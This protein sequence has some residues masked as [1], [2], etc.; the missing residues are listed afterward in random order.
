MAH[1]LRGDRMFAPQWT[2][3][4]AD[5]PPNTGVQV[6]VL[7]HQR[8]ASAVRAAIPIGLQSSNTASQL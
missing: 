6:D 8:R 4:L 5:D 1:E 2:A 3:Q 7:A